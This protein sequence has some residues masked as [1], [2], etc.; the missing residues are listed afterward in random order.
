MRNER[1]HMDACLAA[2]PLAT[3]NAGHSVATSRLNAWARL[4]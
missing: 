1:A 4:S 2:V 3:A